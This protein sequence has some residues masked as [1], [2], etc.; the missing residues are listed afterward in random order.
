MKISPVC[1]TLRKEYSLPGDLWLLQH[2]RINRSNKVPSLSEHK[3]FSP[4]VYLL[5]AEGLLY[6][7]INS[8]PLPPS[9]PPSLG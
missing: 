5:Q 6:F 1:T 9:L 3:Q 2:V 7:C 8:F 4:A